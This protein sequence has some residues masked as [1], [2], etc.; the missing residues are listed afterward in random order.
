MPFRACCETA[1]LGLEVFELVDLGGRVDDVL[2]VWMEGGER[3]W[4][5]GSELDEWGNR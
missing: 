4:K 5:S 3:R 1:F 2:D